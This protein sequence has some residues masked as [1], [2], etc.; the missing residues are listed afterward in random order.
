MTDSQRKGRQWTWER[1]DR[2]AK[3]KSGGNYATASALAGGLFLIL[4]CVALI[5]KSVSPTPSDLE[6]SP[7]AFGKR[8]AGQEIFSNVYLP[9]CE[10]AALESI[11]EPY[12]ALATKTGWYDPAAFTSS[13]A[14]LDEHLKTAGYASLETILRSQNGIGS[15]ANITCTGGLRDTDICDLA[16]TLTKKKS[17]KLGFSIAKAL[18]EKSDPP[19]LAK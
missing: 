4:L 1:W 8:I 18:N 5:M 9:D 16:F 2:L 10:L 11:K 12:K 19:R 15:Y 3:K 14:C 17:T 7:L 6:D 13:M